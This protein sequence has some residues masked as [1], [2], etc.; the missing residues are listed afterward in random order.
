MLRGTIGAFCRTEKD[1]SEGFAPNN[2]FYRS[3]FLLPHV[4]AV[5]NRDSHGIGLLFQYYNHLYYV[6]RRFFPPDRSLGIYFE[7]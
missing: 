3:T 2:N 7:W 6:E 1:G 5:A 4:Y